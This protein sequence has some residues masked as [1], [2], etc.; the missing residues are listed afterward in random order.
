MMLHLQARFFSNHCCVLCWSLPFHL[1]PTHIDIHIYKYTYLHVYMY[2]YIHIYICICIY[3]YICILLYICTYTHTLHIDI[4][5]QKYTYLHVY[6]YMYVY[7]YIYIYVFTCTYVYCYIYVHIHIHTIICN[8]AAFAGN[9]LFQSL[10]HAM[11][12]SSPSFAVKTH[13]RARA[14]ARTHELSPSQVF[15]QVTVARYDGLPPFICILKNTHA[16]ARARAPA[17]ALSL[18]RVLVEISIARYDSLFPF[19]LPPLI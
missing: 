16:R 10:L 14:R 11:M 5:I 18:S 15:I 12:V 1:H 4:H 19:H 6:M 8:D 17:R 3:M 9:V 13:K 7:I 2:I